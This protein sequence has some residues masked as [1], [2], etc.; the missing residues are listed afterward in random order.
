MY[1]LYMPHI[2]CAGHCSE[3][4]NIVVGDVFW[5]ICITCSKGLGILCEQQFCPSTN[6]ILLL[7]A[8]YV[9]RSFATDVARLAGVPREVVDRAEVRGTHRPA[10]GSHR[11]NTKV[12]SRSP[13]PPFLHCTYL[14]H[15]LM[16]SSIS[17]IILFLMK[18]R[19]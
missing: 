3:V 11:Y 12:Y 17:S 4:T 2:L 18:P 5:I 6:Y 9:E 8:G 7:Q 1:T 19:V 13:G 14:G 16:N 15:T 10:C